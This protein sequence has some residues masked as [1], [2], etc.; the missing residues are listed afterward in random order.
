MRNFQLLVSGL[1]VSGLLAG[2]ATQPELWNAHKVRAAHPES[3]HRDVDDI[4]LRYNKFSAGH[5]FLDKVCASID[6]VMYPPWYK[7]PQAHPFIFGLMSRVA[8]V[9]L[10]RCMIS[11]LAPGQIIPAHSD[12]IPPAEKVFPDR[13]PPAIY[14]ERY[15]LPLQAGPGMVFYCGDEQVQMTPG[16]FW[17]FNNQLVHSVVNNSRED[18]IHLIIDIRT[19]LDDYVPG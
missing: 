19:K 13:P 17:W 16:E 2:V 8:G 15:H 5:D 10:G 12:R 7:L 1:D 6:C 9:H 18:R 14:Y 11:R 3:V 4:I